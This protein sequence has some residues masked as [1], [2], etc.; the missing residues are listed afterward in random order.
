MPCGDKV[1]GNRRGKQNYIWIFRSVITA[2]VGGLV[3]ASSL[4]CSSPDWAV[5]AESMVLWSQDTYC[6]HP[7]VL[8]GTGELNAGVTLR[9]SGIPSKD[10]LQVHSCY[11]NCDKL[12]VNWWATWL[13]CRWQIGNRLHLSLSRTTPSIIT[14]FNPFSQKFAPRLLNQS[15][16]Q[17]CKETFE[18][19]SPPKE[20]KVLYLHR[21]NNKSPN[22]STLQ[23]E[24]SVLAKVRFV[25][26]D[27]QER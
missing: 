16:L 25:C 7:G 15:V 19:L 11:R 4:L 5:R 26:K 17:L 2:N 27:P 3:V 6:P 18:M 10:R 22:L 20:T 8:I 13:A 23:R 24:R 1:L 14:A 12:S 9:W 21:Y